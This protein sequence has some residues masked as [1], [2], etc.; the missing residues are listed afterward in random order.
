MVN[1]RWHLGKEIPVT[2]VVM[3]LAQTGVLIWSLSGLY[4]KVEGLVTATN[5]LRMASYTKEDA[6]KAREM[7]LM[8]NQAQ[9]QRDAEQDRRITNLELRK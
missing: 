9:Q 2:F 6:S 4:S 7:L 8:L 3:I 1:T 5:E